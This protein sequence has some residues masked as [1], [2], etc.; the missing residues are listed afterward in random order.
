MT[1]PRTKLEG[2]PPVLRHLWSLL[3]RE[4]RRHAVRHDQLLRRLDA[5]CDRVDELERVVA[6]STS[7]R[8]VDGHDVT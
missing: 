3:Y 8:G 4:A 7:S 1:R 6:T 5:L 2:V